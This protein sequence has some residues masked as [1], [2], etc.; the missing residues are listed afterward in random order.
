MKAVVTTIIILALLVAGCGSSQ[1]LAVS[2]L[3]SSDNDLEVLLGVH[4][5][6]AQA[7]IVGHFSAADDVEWNELTPDQLGGY[8]AF[9]LT[10]DV[11]ITDTDEPSPLGPLLE[12]L[13]AQP[14]IRFEALG[15]LRGSRRSVRPNYIGGTRFTMT[16]DGNIGVNVEYVTG[17]GVPTDVVRIGGS[18]RY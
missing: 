3:S 10:Q 9:F 1:R 11:S 17:D 6:N 4:E 15:P 2:C 7:G 13:H 14:Y 5:G 8:V 16:P 12:S 18:W